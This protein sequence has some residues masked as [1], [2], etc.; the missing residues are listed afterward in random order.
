MVFVSSLEFES[1]LLWDQLY[2]QQVTPHIS[3][4]FFISPS[5]PSLLS[6]YYFLP[7]LL[8][9][10]PYFLHFSNL[11]KKIYI[12]KKYHPSMYQPSHNFPQDKCN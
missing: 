2:C 6:H 12:Q 9:S 3:A 4:I 11:I 7:Y 1:K 5:I 8:P 10:E